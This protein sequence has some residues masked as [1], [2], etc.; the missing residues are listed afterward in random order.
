MP[1]EIDEEV[2][3]S[4]VNDKSEGN[5]FVLNWNVVDKDEDVTESDKEVDKEEIEALA[6]V[7]MSRGQSE[8]DI[9]RV[10]TC[11]G[12]KPGFIAVAKS[13]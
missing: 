11:N 12:T 3:F 7:F 6:T 10:G 4:P 1:G 8:L 9:K 5:Q 2:T 13:T